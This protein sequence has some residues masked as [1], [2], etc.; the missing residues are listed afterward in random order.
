M[1]RGKLIKPT[2]NRCDGCSEYWHPDKC[3]VP[4]KRKRICGDYPNCYH[5]W[6]MLQTL[7]VKERLALRYKRIGK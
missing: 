4:D 3:L 1:K 5:S 2:Y 7:N 6:E